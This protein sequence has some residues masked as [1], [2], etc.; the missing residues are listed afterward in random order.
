MLTQ[1]STPFSFITL[2]LIGTM[3]CHAVTHLV[4]LI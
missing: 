3:K 2:I 4:R 1:K